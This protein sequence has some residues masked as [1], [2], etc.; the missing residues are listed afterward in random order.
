[1]KYSIFNNSLMIDIDKKLYN[2][3]INDIRYPIIYELIK[4]KD[5]LSYYNENKQILINILNVYDTLEEMYNIV[6]IDNDF[7]LKINGNLKKIDTVLERFIK[8]QV[9]KNNYDFSQLFIDFHLIEKVD[10]TSLSKAQQTFQQLLPAYLF[11][12]DNYEIISNRYTKSTIIPISNIDPYF[13]TET[14]SSNDEIE[15]LID[16]NLGNVN[17]IYSQIKTKYY[18]N[19]LLFQMCDVFK[20]DNLTKLSL[21]LGLNYNFFN[22][23][24]NKSKQFYANDIFIKRYNYNGLL[25]L[26]MY[27]DFFNALFPLYDLNDEIMLE[28]YIFNNPNFLLNFIYGINLESSILYKQYRYDF[29]EKTSY[30]YSAVSKTIKDFCQILILNVQNNTIS[31]SIAMEIFAKYAKAN[32]FTKISNIIE[33]YSKNNEKELYLL[34]LIENT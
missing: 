25:N 16:S 7:Y 12:N 26:I 22:K 23:I 2:I 30:D 13:L 9:I 19:N 33:T 17:S 18:R 20:R 15:M 3:H 21:T 8:N 31:K 10:L 4:D 29:T 28:N 11:M 14:S 34:S 24:V 1:M 6:L 27:Y 5:F 32:D